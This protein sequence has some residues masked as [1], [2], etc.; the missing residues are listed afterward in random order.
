MDLHHFIE[1]VIETVNCSTLGETFE[2]MGIDHQK[3]AQSV[4][5]SRDS[6]HL[7]Q[8]QSLM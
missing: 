2:L 1:K 7:L 5:T 4:V 6:F 8:E 3:T